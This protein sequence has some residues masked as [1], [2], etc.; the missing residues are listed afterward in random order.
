[1]Q[2]VSGRGKKVEDEAAGATQW[3]AAA[4]ECGRRKG[5]E[6]GGEECGTI[7]ATSVA[8]QLAPNVYIS[9]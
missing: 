5:Q 8:G 2:E 1:M 9:T 4:W 7:E 6:C 3:G